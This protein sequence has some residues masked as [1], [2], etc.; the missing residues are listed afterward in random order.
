MN[1][2]QDLTDDNFETEIKKKDKPILVDFWANWCGPCK[3][4]APLLDEIASEL[5]DKI[6]ITKVDIDKNPKTPA[7]HAVRGIPTLMIFKDEKVVA[8]QVGAV[9]KEDL[10]KFINENI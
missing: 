9:S 5:K 2:I 8:T 4:M 1:D 6:K 7:N 10:K 3:M